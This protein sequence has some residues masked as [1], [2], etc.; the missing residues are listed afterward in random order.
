MNE[1]ICP[2]CG[3]H[4]SAP[5]AEYCPACRKKRYI[6]KKR[7]TTVFIKRDTEAMRQTCLTCT[8]DRCRGS[9]EMLANVARMRKA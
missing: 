6:E 3:A 8:S 7:K 5:R 2:E 1:K 9:C 4:F